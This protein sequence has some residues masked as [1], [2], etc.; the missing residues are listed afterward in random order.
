M[1]PKS[2]VLLTVFIDVVGFGIIIPVLPFY[3]ES[4]N[5][6]PFVLTLL[7]SVYALCSFI[8]APFLGALSDKV[9]RRPILLISIFS[10]A[11]GW[12]IFSFA[13]NVFMLFL[14][15]IIDGL[16]AG[17]ISTARS[18]MVD[19]AGNDKNE[20][21]K[22][23]GMIG[24]IFGVGF[25]IGPAI[26]G[27]T[28]A[29]HGSM[30]FIM[31]ATMSSFNFLLAYFILPETL[32]HADKKHFKDAFKVNPFSPLIR[33]LKDKLRSL[34]YFSWLLMLTSAGIYQAIFA[35]YMQK[36]FGRGQGEVGLAMAITGGMMVLA[37]IYILPKITKMFEEDVIEKTSFIMLVVSYLFMAIPN[38]IVFY[39]GM[40]LSIL[41]Q[42]MLRVT[43]NHGL[44]NNAGNSQGEI[45]GVTGALMSVSMIFGP[46]IAGVAFSI[47]F[48]S[49]FI[50]VAIVAIWAMVSASKFRLKNAI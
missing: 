6:N 24:A 12:F 45:M 43:I 17:N 13:S 48:A 50:L 22:A 14:G 32:A 16:A 37:Q 40:T 10:S 15:R 19:M 5:V 41:S 47:S 4:F 35:V 27:L 25:I 44:L 26:G 34:G 2:A 42:S 3:V 31:V 8:S 1:S 23:M 9:G 49:V 18:Y 20:R 39:F 7:F 29:L 21:M 46:M 38:I 30:P 11:V 28:G 33:A 36:V